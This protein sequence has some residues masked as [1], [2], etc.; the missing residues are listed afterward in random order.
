MAQ[1]LAFKMLFRR[2][3]TA[4]TILVIALLIAL[5]ASVTSLVNNVN[6]QTTALTKLANVNKTYIVMDAASDSVLDSRVD[7]SVVALLQN[8]SDV[9]GVVSQTYLQAKVRAESGS[10]PVV[11]RGVDSP[12]SFFEACNARINGTYAAN[13][14]Q[15][16]V[17][18]ILANLC[19]I[20]VGA[21]VSLA[22]DGHVL[23][24]NVTGLVRTS[25]Q[26]DSEIVISKEALSTLLGNDGWVSIVGFAP[27]NADAADSLIP[28]LN[29][30]L[31]AS[32]KIVSVQQL[33][34]FAV[35]VNSQI[36]SFLNLWS[37][38]IYVVVVAASY[39]VAARLIAEAQH[40]LAMIRILGGKQ[41]VTFQVVLTHTVTVALFG[42][43]L[44][45]A[46][47]LAGAQIA[48][49]GL[50]WVWS[51]M[52]VTPFLDAA[53]TLQ[54]L[55]LAFAASIAGCIYPA[56]KSTRKPPTESPL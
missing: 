47:G 32:V 50:R 12:Q 30:L 24:V 9:K 36:L 23:V 45:L 55:A 48:S 28:R 33:D 10:Y 25:T 26:I 20:S 27:K 1:S 21:E 54:I 5:V 22:V 8:Y 2:K 19:S 13:E 43:V 7:P 46:I 29:R 40:E 31:P 16:N 37:A 4:S 6:S 41:R 3:G 17:G 53:Q 49:T 18:E 42:A 56:F 39:I 35:D 15:V 14:T 51:S 34:A 11:L 38:V 44:G 52:Q